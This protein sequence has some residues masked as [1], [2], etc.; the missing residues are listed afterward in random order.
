MAADADIGVAVWIQRG[1]HA[2][3]RRWQS[4]PASSQD[5][6][7]RGKVSCL[8]AFDLD[9]L[10]QRLKGEGLPA[11]T[12]GGSAWTEYRGRWGGLAL[13]NLPCCL[14]DGALSLAT[15]EHKL[16]WRLWGSQ[17]NVAFWH[18]CDFAL[19]EA[20]SQLELG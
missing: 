7:T 16:L 10:N 5:C 12:P 9:L 2:L 14:Y 13:V 4:K 1:H 6:K 8:E 19:F 11:W 20:A 17:A 18:V 15:A 3:E